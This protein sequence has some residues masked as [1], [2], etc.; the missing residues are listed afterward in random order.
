MILCNTIYK[1]VKMIFEREQL[2]FFWWGLIYDNV[3][4]RLENSDFPTELQNLEP[5]LGWEMNYYEDGAFY[6][7]FFRLQQFKA[8][9]LLKAQENYLIIVK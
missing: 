8:K 5:S 6:F 7:N 2:C 3:N 1:S 4:K 9:I